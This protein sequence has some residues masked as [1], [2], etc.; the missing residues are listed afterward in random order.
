MKRFVTAAVAVVALAGLVGLAFAHGPMAGGMGWMGGMM[1]AR[2][3]GMMGAGPGGAG[4]PGM[5]AAGAAQAPGA[6]VTEERARE[7]AQ[8]YASRYLTGFTVERVL[9][10]QA[11]H[12]T[13]YSVELKGPREEVRVLHVNPWGSV[14][15]FGGPGR[16]AG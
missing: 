16:H 7:L 12:G 11:M 13:A 5:A 9:P 6:Q 14:M 15:P 8:E 4:C 3:P 10:F 2:G 1:G